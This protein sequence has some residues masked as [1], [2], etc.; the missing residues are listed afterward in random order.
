MSGQW[1][2]PLII[3]EVFLMTFCAAIRAM[4]GS[5]LDCM[6]AFLK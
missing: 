6:E 1:A 3:T 5:G 4:N 2:V